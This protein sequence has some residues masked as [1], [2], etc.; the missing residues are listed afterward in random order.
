MGNFRPGGRG[1]EVGPARSRLPNIATGALRSITSREEGRCG[2]SASAVSSPSPDARQRCGS[3]RAP[4]TGESA[5]PLQLPNCNVARAASYSIPCPWVSS[6]TGDRGSRSTGLTSLPIIGGNPR[7]SETIISRS[8]HDQRRV[9]ACTHD[10]FAYNCQGYHLGRG[11][12]GLPREAA[13]RQRAGPTSADICPDRWV[14]A[15]PRRPRSS[16]GGTSQT[17]RPHAH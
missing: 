1:A 11:A 17:V 2:L 16:I 7:R 10:D 12:D 15:N 13:H 4:S 3:A 5:C 14:S 8:R 9:A 6:G